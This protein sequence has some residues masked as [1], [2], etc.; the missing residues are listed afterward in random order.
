[1]LHRNNKETL[2]T[3]RERMEMAMKH[4]YSRMPSQVRCVPVRAVRAQGWFGNLGRACTEYKAYRTSLGEL[5]ALK[6]AQPGDLGFSRAALKDA[7]RN[8]VYGN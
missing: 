2:K 7:A 6:D 3:E 1:M 5:R 4:A 8:A